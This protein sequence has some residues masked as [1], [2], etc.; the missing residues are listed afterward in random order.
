M[1]NKPVYVNLVKEFWKHAYLDHEE[2][3]ITSYIFEIPITITPFSIVL[4][5]GCESIGLTVD[6]VKTKYIMSDKFASLHDLSSGYK[7]IDPDNLLPIPKTW[8]KLVLSN[9]LPREEN[10]DFLRYNDQSIIY[11]LMNDF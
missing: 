7:P 9:L 8:F 10:Q 11:L 3:S 2:S 1:L 5:T 6:Y 4:A